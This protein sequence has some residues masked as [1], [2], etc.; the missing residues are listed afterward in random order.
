LTTTGPG[1]SYASET[2]W[3]WGYDSV[4]GYDVG[5]GGGTNTTYSFPSYQ[6]GINMTTNGGSTACRNVPDVALTADNVYVR[7]G[8]ADNDGVGGTSCAAP[9]WAAFTAL[10]NQ[11]V[12]AA[13]KPALGFL[14]PTVYAVAQTS[15]YPNCFHDIV[16]G[17]NT[18]S[19]SP[20]LYYAVPGYDLCTGLGTPNGTNLVN[21]LAPFPACLSQPVSQNVTNG[22]NV[23]FS[24]AGAGAPALSFQWL[25]NGTNLSDGGNITGSDGNDLSLSAVNA[26]NVGNYSLVLSNS[27]GSLTSSFPPS[28]PI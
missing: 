7:A 16:I 9:L 8:G 14:N 23:V 27:Y 18:N 12:V 11:Q 10:V 4:A 22:A 21:A 25:F 13:G 17:N 15:N 1:G 3:Q 5:S 28:P 19:V 26:G 20:N 24:V 6:Q 2:V